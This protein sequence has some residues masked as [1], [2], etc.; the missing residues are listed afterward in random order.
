MSID[1]FVLAKAVVYL[2][3]FD[4]YRKV[5]PAEALI[6]YRYEDV[7]YKKEA[8]LRQIVVDLELPLDMTLLKKTAKQFNVFPAHENQNQHIRQVHPGNYKS[9][10]QPE[11][12]DELTEKLGEFLQCYNY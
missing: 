8:W 9:K 10:L 11:T 2:N 3:N 4:K 6:T 5:L 7:I 1:E 12:I